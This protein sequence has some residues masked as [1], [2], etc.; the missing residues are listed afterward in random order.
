MPISSVDTFFACSLMVILVVTGMAALTKVVQPY[1]NNLSEVNDLEHFKEISENFLLSRGDPTHWGSTADSTIASFGLASN[2][3]RPY[4]L[5]IDKVTRL[6]NQN[7]FSISYSDIL[8]GLSFEDTTLKLKINSLFRIQI[9]LAS[10]L[11]GENET[12]YT[13]QVS[14]E[15]SGSQISAQLQCYT[16][17]ENHVENSTS[18]TDKGV[19]F[20][21]VSLPNSLEGSGLFLVHARAKANAQLIAFS[22]YSFGHN[23]DNP[24]SNGTYLRLSPLNHALNVSFKYPNLEVSNAFAFTHNYQFN[25]TKTVEKNQTEKYDIPNLLDPSPTILVLNGKNDTTSFIEWVAYPQLPLEIGA[26]FH[27]ITP[28]RTIVL[29]YSV[30]IGSGLYELVAS[31]QHV[32]NQNA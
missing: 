7:V 19:A 28:S 12:V 23:S 4:E 20:I 3:L 31:F 16:V 11:D 25:L 9:S 17:I 32:G 30:I 15:K 13:F 8:A 29:T 21:T 6:N 22:T 18:S 26:D 10:R 27:S 24:Q 2:S 1:L 5:D 14:T